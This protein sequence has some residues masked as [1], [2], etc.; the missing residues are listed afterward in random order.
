MSMFSCGWLWLY[1]GAIL[2]LMEIL[3]P[4]F[5]IFFFGLAAATAGCSWPIPLHV[6][7]CCTNPPRAVRPSRA[8]H[9][10]LPRAGGICTLLAMSSVCTSS[11][12]TAVCLNMR[13]ISYKWRTISVFSRTRCHPTFFHKL[14]L[15][16][17]QTFCIIGGTCQC[18]I[19][20]PAHP[21]KCLAMH[22]IIDIIFF[23]KC[24]SQTNSNG[25]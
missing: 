18:T 24:T 13:L 1:A 8:L 15:N 25:F 20:H 11:S 16:R 21:A 22:T 3:A 4:G 5:V 6:P 7:V 12:A 9:R 23:S 17:L 14:N 19:F 10:R 2:M